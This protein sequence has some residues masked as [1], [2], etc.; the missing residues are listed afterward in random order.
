MP[1]PATDYLFE[2]G[3]GDSWNALGNVSLTVTS[4]APDSQNNAIYLDG[5]SSD[6]YQEVYKF[7]YDLKDSELIG[8]N[9]ELP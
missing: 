2:S 1:K 7:S 9:Q 6:G 8:T 5:Y 4:I 3:G